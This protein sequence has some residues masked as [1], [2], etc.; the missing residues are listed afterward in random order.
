MRLVRKK[1]GDSGGRSSRGVK[2]HPELNGR[3]SSDAKSAEEIVSSK[4]SSRFSLAGADLETERA[5]LR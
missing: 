5:E 3:L 1:R 4:P 2:D